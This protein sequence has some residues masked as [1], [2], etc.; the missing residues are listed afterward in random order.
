M[1]LTQNNTVNVTDSASSLRSEDHNQAMVIFTDKPDSEVWRA[2]KKGDEPAFNYIYRKFVPVLFNYGYQVC[3]DD[4]M[5]K[6]CIQ[7]LFMDLRR[8]RSRLAEVRSIKGYLF[9]IFYRELVRQ[10]K[11]K[12]NQV[13]EPIDSN[14]GIF[15]IEVSH[16]TKLISK[17]WDDEIKAALY[18]ALNKLPSRQR[19]AL[20]LLY[21]ENLSYEEIAQ[22]ME[23]KE[24][25]TA[26]TLVY[27]AISSMKSLLKVA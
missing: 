9:T 7:G 6:D 22:V 17:E 19:Q 21:R 23:F 25:K 24:V 1:K 27:R 14:E 4:G 2:F 13:F 15:P 26:R 16:E 10:L 18:K 3:K 12:Q 11:S 20:L 8:K 5:V